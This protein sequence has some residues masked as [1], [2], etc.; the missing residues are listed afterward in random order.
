MQEMVEKIILGEDEEVFNNVFQQV[1]MRLLK[2]LIK[3][4]EE[5]SKQKKESSIA[6]VSFYVKI[7]S[8]LQCPLLDG[9]IPDA[10]N[11]Q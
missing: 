9:I 8:M 11:D 1:N 5:S 7:M 6:K 3:T 2:F 4:A 10:V